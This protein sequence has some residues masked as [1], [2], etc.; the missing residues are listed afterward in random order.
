MRFTFSL[1]PDAGI[2]PPFVRDADAPSEAIVEAADHLSLADVW[3]KAA[4]D[5]GFSI[6]YDIDQTVGEAIAFLRF[7][8]PDDV[9]HDTRR[10]LNAKDLEIVDVDGRVSFC[11]TLEDS[12]VADLIRTSDAGL[13]GGDVARPYFIPQVPGGATEWFVSWSVLVGGYAMVRGLLALI[14]DIEGTAAFVE[15]VRRG[16]TAI[17]EQA[18]ELERRRARPDALYDLLGRRPWAGADVEVLL[19]CDEGTAI[20]LLQLFG[21]ELD[22][23][24][25]WRPGESKD[26][27]L[28]RALLDEIITTAEHGAG[29]SGGSFED[30][31]RHLLT[32]GNRAELPSYLKEYEALEPDEVHVAD[33]QFDEDD[34]DFDGFDN[35]GLDDAELNAL[36]AID[37]EGS[38]SRIAI[39]W[40]ADPRELEGDQLIV[41]RAIGFSPED[42]EDVTVPPGIGIRIEEASVGKGASGTGVGLILE[43][44]EHIINDAAGLIA[45]GYFARSMIDKVSNRRGRQPADA[46]PTAL[47][48]LAAAET[49]SLVEAPEG[50]YHARTVPLTTDGSCGTDMRDVWASAFVDESRGVVHVVFSSSTTRQLGVAV[51][52]QEWFFDGSAGRIRS[53]AELAAVLEIGLKP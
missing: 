50:W 44:A 17:I 23:Q 27:I 15:R 2:M 32:H 31:V 37:D 30:R 41:A 42:L 52:G 3:A 24:G 16:S 19:G 51:V 33:D 7:V 18:P 11:R 39:T 36:E 12:T 48:A 45:L 1:V 22:S 6:G 47:A 13:I 21:F 8:A 20:A 10:H 38:D 35:E 25:L 49:P 43:I 34:L 53:D 40:G 26:A 46:S 28:L 5:L 9:G 14:A 29:S 4:S